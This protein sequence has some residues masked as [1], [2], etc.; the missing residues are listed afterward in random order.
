MLQACRACGRSELF[1][2]LD[3]GQ[4]PLA[5]DFRS[6]GE[7]NRLYPLAIDGCASCGLLQVR[8]TVDRSVLF[9]PNYSYASSTVPVLVRHFE[10]Y[11]KAVAAFAEK[12]GRPKKLLEVGCND[13][14]FLEPLTRVGFE[15]VGIDASANVGA[16]AQERGLQVQVGF[17]DGASARELVNK[18]GPFDVV[19]CSNVFAHNPDMNDFLSAVHLALASDGEFWVEVH[20]AKRLFEALQWDCF[21]H[22]HCFYWTIHT[23][24]SALARHDLGLMAHTYTPMHG[25]AI[26]AAFAKGKA[27]IEIHEPPV[28]PQDWR[29]FGERC[30]RS[31]DAIRACL[32]KLPIRYAYGAAGR[33]VCLINWTGIEDSLQF[34][35]D[36]SP[37]RAGKA[38]PNTRIPIIPESEYFRRSDLNEW[39]FVTAHNYLEEIRKKVEAN[40][41]DQRT[42]F[43]MPLPHVRVE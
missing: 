13:G 40:W 17:F 42:W 5:G 34:V 37:L 14:V 29:L 19:T 15:A 10:A 7:P 26:R 32:A 22:E 38:I 35:V 21:Y 31:R 4:M 36:G 33:A 20:D 12:G 1:E 2:V 43:V 8:E 41:S 6:M 39:C 25:G 16:M 30:E 23:L 3:M 11:A 28:A 18:Y 24:T 27:G 9:H